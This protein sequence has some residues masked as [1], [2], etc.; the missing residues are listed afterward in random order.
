MACLY[1][2]TG[3]TG[4]GKTEQALAWAREQKAEILSCDALLVYQGMT[5]GTAKP[6]RE[7]QALV[8]HHGMDLVPVQR[9]YSIGDYLTMAQKVVR[10][11]TARGRKVLIT[12]GSGFYLKSFFAP[13]VDS[14]AIPL[15][16][17]RHVQTIEARQGLIGL[18]KQLNACNPKGVDHIDLKNPRR[19]ANA[20]MRCL[21]SGKTLVELQTR[22]AKKNSPF[23]HYTKQVTCLIRDR[24]DLHQR[25]ERRTAQMLRDGLIDEVKALLKAG[26]AS[27][28]QSASAIGYRETIAWL[29]QGEPK[30]EMLQTAI[31][32]NTLKLVKKQLTW[33]RKQF[34]PGETTYLNLSKKNNTIF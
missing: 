27:N 22:F 17:R 24:Q 28:P 34:S 12:G 23:A 32:R 33:L 30:Q 15:A 29:R 8:P 19:V 18:Q 31:M 11:I 26:I 10:A 4:V 2:L 1:V 14:V 25:I 9:P 3:P 20:L 16:I 5:I 6:N 7:Q 21:A 13:V